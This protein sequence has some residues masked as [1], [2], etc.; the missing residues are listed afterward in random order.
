MIKN[1]SQVYTI[2]NTHSKVLPASTRVQLINHQ[3]M[4]DNRAKHIVVSDNHLNES[5]HQPYSQVSHKS[6]S[7]GVTPNTVHSV[8]SKIPHHVQLKIPP[9]ET[10]INKNEMAKTHQLYKD[11]SS[12]GIIGL[13]NS[14]KY[15]NL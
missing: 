3:I 10:Y 6:R 8:P 14:L 15:C 7:T 1:T 5:Y 2:L 9:I 11:Q 12:D 13:F 4:D